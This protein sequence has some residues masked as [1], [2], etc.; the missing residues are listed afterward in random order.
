M[1]IQNFDKIR[2]ERNREAATQIWDDV[3]TRITAFI[4]LS[5]L[6]CM[7]DDY[8]KLCLE[9]MISKGFQK[10]EEDSKGADND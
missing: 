3:Q 6:M 10:W 5:K 1:G 9:D 4:S 7:G 2:R 8:I